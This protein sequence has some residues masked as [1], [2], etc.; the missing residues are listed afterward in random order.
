MLSPSPA[1]CRLPQAPGVRV[2]SGNGNV[3]MAVGEMEDVALERER[4]EHL[5]GGPTP[6]IPIVV[7]KGVFLS[8]LFRFGGRGGGYKG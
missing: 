1:A 8:C 2:G 3:M 4:V 6:D 5:A 7:R